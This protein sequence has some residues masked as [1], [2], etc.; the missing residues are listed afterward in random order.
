MTNQSSLKEHIFDYKI[1]YEQV[2]ETEENIAVFSTTY[3]VA[4]SYKK[5]I[6]P[7]TARARIT[8]VY[9][10][11][12]SGMIIHAGIIEKW[13]NV[14]WS[15]IEEYHDD[16]FDFKSPVEFRDR[17]VSHLKSFL[18]G[19]SLEEIDNKYE[20]ATQKKIDEEGE[21]QAE[22]NKNTENVIDFSQRR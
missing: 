17:L 10:Y 6:E 21:G 8:C 2:S 20:D 14:S 5:D 3:S 19:I 11:D 22:E 15:T 12:N 16:R 18:L 4:Y 9:G 7:L 1:L 13:S